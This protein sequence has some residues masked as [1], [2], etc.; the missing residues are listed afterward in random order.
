[1][2]IKQLSKRSPL[3]KLFGA[4]LFLSTFIFSCSFPK[5]QANKS[6]HAMV[7]SAHPLASEIGLQIIKNGG[8]AVDAAVA[9][10]F[11][12]AVVY[13]SAGNI[14][15]G[16]FFVYRSNGGDCSTLDFRE[17]APLNAQ[18]DMYLDTLGNV[19][20]NLSLIGHLAVGVPGTV[21][22]MVTIHEKYGRLS[23]EKVIQPSIDLANNG[24]VLTE[25]QARNLN[26]FNKSKLNFNDY[27]PYFKDT[28]NKGDTLLLRDLGNTLI[29]IREH[30]REGFYKG[31]VAD[32]IVEEMQKNNGLI[33]HDDL[34][35]YRSV[36]REPIVFPYKK[37]NIIT[38]GPPSSGGIVLAQLMKMTSIF[39]VAEMGF[40]SHSSVHL[41]SEIERRAFADRSKYLGDPDF[42]DIPQ[43]QLLD[44]IYL[45]KRLNNINLS[46]ATPSDSVHPGEL[47]FEESDETTHFSIVDEDGNAVSITTTL[48][49]SYGSGVIVDGAGF[50]LN[51][52]MDDFSI[53]PG[54]PNL[55]GL[56]G[57]EANAIAPEKRMLSSMTPSIVEKNDSLYLVVGSPG[58][59]AIITAVYQ[60]L[61]NVIEFE[62][63]IDSAVNS[64]RFHHQWKPDQIKMEQ[65]LSKNQMLIDAL[66]N[67]GHH[68]K[69]VSSMNRVDAILVK[70][71]SLFGGADRRG[72]DFAA[73]Y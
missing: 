60:T 21:D 61:L 46:H 58:G 39:D 30:K 49:G 15:G 27:N 12:L 43:D 17:K 35:S 37:Y 64:P 59:S 34:E 72:D 3:F 33:G 24:F 4:G 56:I 70:N 65:S 23:W 28:Y 71:D 20:D 40:H 32:Q 29:Q 8:N 19:V 45:I 36:W 11:A 7:V 51:N 47:L 68:I 25:K 42:Y 53:K 44:S 54:Y 55:Y 14:G 13:P 62:M 31:V 63:S 52:E 9:V 73:G 2:I 6:K 41:M 10:Q 50:L 57:G 5:E 1:M 48:N 26:Y 67:Y 16:G 66:K 18:R 69:Y 38:M 22:G